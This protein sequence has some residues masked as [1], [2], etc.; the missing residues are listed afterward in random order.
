MRSEPAGL[1]N[2]SWFG[3]PQNKVK[4]F[5]ANFALPKGERP[6]GMEWKPSPTVCR[7]DGFNFKTQMKILKDGFDSY[8]LPTI[9][10]DRSFFRQ[11]R[12]SF[13]AHE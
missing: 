2:A 6:R 12:V 5:L 4:A 9:C 1:L 11:W 10:G 7:N 13:K 3:V 8:I